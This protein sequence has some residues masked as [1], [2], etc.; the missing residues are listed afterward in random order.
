MQTELI[1]VRRETETG[2]PRQRTVLPH[3]YMYFVPFHRSCWSNP[4][5]P[6]VTPEDYEPPGFQAT[7]SDDF[8][9]EDNP[10]TIRVGDVNT[11]F[12]A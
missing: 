7:T 4:L 12:H 5:L 2:S 11:P 8:L 9:F 10:V 6:A 1:S 3:I